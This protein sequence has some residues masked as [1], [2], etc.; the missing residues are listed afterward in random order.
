MSQIL[1]NPVLFNLDGNAT[2]ESQLNSEE[3]QNLNNG[4]LILFV[5]KDKQAET[6]YRDLY[7]KYNDEYIL[8]SGFSRFFH[9]DEK[10]NADEIVSTTKNGL[11]SPKLLNNLNLLM[12]LVDTE[13]NESKFTNL[14]NSIKEINK[15]IDSLNTEILNINN[16]IETQITK[17]KDDFLNSPEL[18]TAINKYIEDKIDSIKNSLINH[19]HEPSQ[20]TKE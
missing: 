5:S 8:I 10:I 19:T 20:E 16:N 3:V 9:L 13:G 1:F 2:P 17:L 6:K 12:T 18:K 14:D 7:L 11:M 15:K 4:S